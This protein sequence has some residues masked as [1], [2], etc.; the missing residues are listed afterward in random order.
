M[1]DEKILVL[2]FYNRK[3]IGD[4]S[5][6]LAFPK[7]LGTTNISF[8][9]VDDI[10]ELPDNIDVVICGGGDVVNDYFMKKIQY[11]L[12]DFLGR[13]YAVSVGIPY[14][15]SINYLSMFDH[16]F[17]RSKT[18]YNLTAEIIGEENVTFINDAAFSIQVPP[19]KRIVTPFTR[20]GICLA[21]PYFHNNIHKRLLINSFVKSLQNIYESNNNIE[22][23]LVPFNQ[24]THSHHECDFIINDA[25]EN[26]LQKRGIPV[27]N[28][29]E[30]NSPLKILSFFQR[31][32]DMVIG[33]RYHS[34]VFSMLTNR[35]FIPI[36]VSQ[37]IDNLLTDIN[38]DE[39]YKI[40]LESDDKFMPT[41]IDT[42][43]LTSAIKY[44]LDTLNVEFIYN[45]DMTPIKKLI[46]VDK[47]Y[48]S[49]LIKSKLRSFND[50]LSTC[51]RSLSKYLHI[52]VNTYDSLLYS[53]QPFN[54]NDKS[55]LDIARFICFLISGQ[56]HH[57]CVWG[58]SDNLLNSDFCL[59]DSLKFIWEICKLSVDKT[60]KIQSYYPKLD[61]TYTRRAVV[62]LDYVFPNDFSQFHR[63][64]WSYAIGGLMN[65]DA[66]H[67]SKTS[68][69]MLDTYV[70]RSFHWGKDI[71]TYIGLLPYTQPWY[72]FIHHTFDE[73]HSEY[74]CTKL[75]KDDL[76]IKSLEYCKGLI[77]LSHDLKKTMDSELQKINF[78][79]PV[80]AVY[81]PMEFIENNTFTMQKFLNNPN[82]GIVNI[83]A[84]LRNPYSIF[85]LPI[86]VEGNHIG[87]KKMALKGKEMDQYFPPPGFLECLS[88]LLLDTDWFNVNDPAG[89]CRDIM[90]RDPMSRDCNSHDPISRHICRDH[91][92]AGIN[93]YCQGLYDMILRQYNSVTILDRLSNEDYDNLLSQNIVFLNL[94][95]CSAVNTI[96]E[97]IVRNTVLIINRLPATQEMLG[98]D[99]PGFYNTFVDAANIC[100][101]LEKIKA[102][103]LYMT[104]L[105]KTRYKLENFVNSIQDI[106]QLGTVQV[107][108]ETF[109]KPPKTIFDKK[110]S[111]ISRFLPVT[112]KNMNI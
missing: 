16:V 105:D 11:L 17:V 68:D 73:S 61:N 30:L 24:M 56:T 38:Y 55:T 84:W 77:V 60:N 106:V 63:S 10:E 35:R 9:C 80:F 33:M 81:H 7:I 58:L 14:T 18:D 78:N 85:E 96:I 66:T 112:F 101:D 4:D 76:F 46:L 103:H 89:I 42:Q 108:F 65:I 102:I 70:D 53:K 79:V 107:E 75:L 67:L 43:N 6:T 19:I 91:G 110:Y 98:D 21:Q 26:K 3:N 25:I 15:D 59:F 40:K 5:Y 45:F 90:S 92:P 28:H 44:A 109:V 20:I 72:G 47:K 37:K 31:N 1:N 88:D 48:M 29:S 87:I 22:F 86:P 36:Y 13:S 99:Y 8:V 32:L 83:G 104:K 94:V 50:V 34:I 23:H 74:N 97:C 100:N 111:W 57:P 12:K 69:I 27:V 51:R 54:L 71:L 82:K 52:N 62:N 95:D 39:N 41:G 2:G 93:K 49:I 64:G